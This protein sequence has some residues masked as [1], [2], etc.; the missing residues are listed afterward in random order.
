MNIQ[1]LSLGLI[2]IELLAVL[3]Y[4]GPDQILPI[5]SI[6]GSIIGVLLIWWRR[7]VLLVRKGWMRFF[8]RA[9]V[10]TKK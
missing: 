8:K 6:I 3:F 5:I 4:T 7:L 1:N 10:A 9:P 2:S